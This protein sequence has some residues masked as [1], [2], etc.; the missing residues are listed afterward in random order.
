MFL[1]PRDL[2]LEPAQSVKHLLRG[3]F[4]ESI[5]IARHMRLFLDYVRI[6]HHDSMLCGH[7]A[8]STAGERLLWPMSVKYQTERDMRTDVVKHRSRVCF[9]ESGSIVW[10]E[11]DVSDGV[12]ALARC[13]FTSLNG[14]LRTLELP[15]IQFF[16][17]SDNLSLDD[18]TSA[19]KNAFS[20]NTKR[21]GQPQYRCQ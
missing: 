20:L 9:T 16:G 18:F 15:R 14:S 5:R 1:A 2:P 11:A 13:L 6:A 12:L 8:S 21:S 3:T 10:H 17:S 7:S 4:T 19:K